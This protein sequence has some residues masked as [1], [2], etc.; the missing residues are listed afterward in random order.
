VRG[1]RQL[2]CILT[3]SFASWVTFALVA[4]AQIN[5]FHWAKPEWAPTPIIP[6]NNPMTEAKVQLGRFLFYDKR[7]SSDGSMSCATC[8]QQSRAFTDGQPMHV[9][10]TGEMGIR[11]SMTLTNVAYLS[12]YTWANPQ[13]GSLEKQMLIP[14]F[15][16]HPVEMAMQ[17]HDSELIKSLKQNAAYRQMFQ[18]AFPSQSGE[19]TVAT[20]TKAIATFE[21]T[22]LS[23]NSAYDRYK[24][25]EPDALSPAAKRG[26]ALFFGERLE[27]YHCHGGTN[28]T[29][30]NMQQGQAF[31]EAGFHNTGLY[32]EDGFG[33]Y[34]KWDSGV[35]MVTEKEEDEG[36]FR[37]PTLR[38]IGVTAPYM[39]DGS[40]PTLE[41]VIRK[42]YAVKGQSALTANGAS[43]LRDEFIEGFSINEGEVKDLVAFLNSLTDETFLNDPAFADP[44]TVSLPVSAARSENAH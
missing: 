17:G 36:K 27:C 31:P 16:D 39:H 33:A 35:R 28:F 10:V 29:D 15:S 40:I 2:R 19:I 9:G 38:N 5:G 1:T 7:L 34:K 23:F 11:S 26:E 44:R 12:S 30:N 21:R 3:V 13:I 43:P 20:I 4:T 22:L 24:H 25:G 14:L 41:E 37:T 6:A 42:H 18:D 8:H 32:N